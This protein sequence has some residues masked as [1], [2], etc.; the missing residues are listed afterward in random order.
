ML[1]DMELEVDKLPKGQRSPA[2]AN[3]MFA[4]DTFGKPSSC[5]AQPPVF[6][7]QK[8]NPELVSIACKE[9]LGKFTALPAKDESGNVFTSVQT[10]TVKFVKQNKKR[11]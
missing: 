4:V 7:S 8:V 2:F 11:Q 10:G 3:V 1:G 5:S 6:R 9:L